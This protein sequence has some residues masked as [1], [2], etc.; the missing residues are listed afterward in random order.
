[1]RVTNGMV[2]NNTLNS[3]YSNMARLDTLYTQMSTLKKVQRPSDDPIVT[4]RALKLRVN[5]LEVGQY[6]SNTDEATS[7][8]SVTEKALSNITE[9]IKDIRTR[10]V[11]A[12]T[13]TLEASDREKIKVDIDQLWQQLQQ[14][15]NATY[16]G[17]HVF[18]GYKT[19]EPIVLAKDTVLKE[20]V[21]TS[22]SILLNGETILK[23]GTI[24]PS[25]ITLKNATVI[26]A[27]TLGADIS[28]PEG[29]ILPAATELPAGTILPKGT[30][31]PNVLGKTDDQ[32]IQYEIGV[33]STITVNTLG[34]DSLMSGILTD[35]SKIK[36]DLDAYIDGTAGANIDLHQLFQEK[37]GDFDKKL[38][39]LSEMTA[40]LGSRM[41]RLEYT[42]SRLEDDKTNFTELLSKTEDVD[43][44]EIYTQFNAQYAVYQ[45]A[46]QAT[47]KVIMNTLADFLR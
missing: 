41:V 4:G 39:K 20:N 23:A 6:K 44:E 45:S 7:W 35:V 43:L 37:I 36:N 13:D 34:M 5:V 31:N 10:C 40:D 46:L 27:G 19:N 21:I 11:Q 42:A 38:S 47:S 14:E 15:A 18:S 32:R 25:P 12:S 8:M 26:P 22:D 28:V 29:T 1:M 9:I 16:V 17:R 24:I 2:R 30:I 33:G 3:L